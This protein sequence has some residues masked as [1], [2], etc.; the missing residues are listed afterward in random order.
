M[1]ENQLHQINI[2]PTV[3][4]QTPR[5]DFA[6]VV[7]RTVAGAA[8]AGADLIAPIASSHPVLSAAVSAVKSV[9]QGALAQVAGGA[10]AAGGPGG[11]P[12]SMIDANRQLM[13]EGA[14]INQAYL[15]LQR[16]MQ[17]ESQQYNTLSNVMKVRHDSAK[18]AINN[19]R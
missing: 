7:A 18:A 3:E 13:Y 14:A 12:G 16:D 4:R 1:P 8:S 5:R 9:A 2:T 10:G 11:D 6:D 17:Q 19:I 15:K